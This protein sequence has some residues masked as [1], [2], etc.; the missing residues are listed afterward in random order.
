MH[1]VA[2]PLRNTTSHVRPAGLSSA[3]STT[4]HIVATASPRTR[5]M[6][7]TT[8]LGSLARRS[9]S[10]RPYARPLTPS[11]ADLAA[12]TYA[13]S[14]VCSPCLCPVWGTPFES[15]STESRPLAGSTQVA[16]TD[17]FAWSEPPLVRLGPCEPRT[18]AGASRS[19]TP[20]SSSRWRGQPST[21]RLARGLSVQPQN[22]SW[23]NK[24]GGVWHHETEHPRPGRLTPASPSRAKARAIAT[25]PSSTAEKSTA[26][27]RSLASLTRG[28]MAI[29]DLSR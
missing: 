26:T 23:T 8:G 18:L 14:A 6:S 16:D 28:A 10:A 13:T 2:P 4:N 9:E 29:R 20:R 19:S 15:S 25:G 22:A 21:A 11:T 1:V 24:H 5:I 27:W 7:G 17:R 3:G 12:D